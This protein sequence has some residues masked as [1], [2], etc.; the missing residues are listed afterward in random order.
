MQKALI[1]E[2][3]MEIIDLENWER[4]E[5]FNFFQS[6]K[7]CQYGVTVQQDVSPL[8]SF[9]KAANRE[10]RGLRFSDML[11]YFATRAANAVP[12]LRTRLVDGNPV[13]F[14]V[15]HPAFTYIPKGRN[16]HAN[17]LACYDEVYSNTERNIQSAR[18][19][20]DAAP[21]L[22]PAGGDKQNLL[23]FSITTGVP[24][25][26]ASNPWGDCQVDSV[27]RILFGQMTET[28]TG[29]MILPISIELLH[30]L[31][32]GKHLAQFLSLINDMCLNPE[33]FID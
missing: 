28:E 8:W 9:R 21:T 33:K 11:Y 1:T 4:T 20:S 6:M 15:I 26:S 10:G 12:E 27:P 13:I 7:S 19:N 25:T 24:F 29:K 2:S 30:S 17:V 18:D 3:N 23:Y 32:D 16:L 22:T 14:D 31:A 5:H